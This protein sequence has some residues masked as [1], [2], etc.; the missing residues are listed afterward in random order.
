MSNGKGD[1]PRPPSR[2]DVL[3]CGE[4]G[5]AM[6]DRRGLCLRCGERLQRLVGEVLQEAERVG[7]PEGV[8]EFAEHGQVEAGAE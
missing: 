6:R 1:S 3:R 2:R 4:V 5:H 7:L 8:P